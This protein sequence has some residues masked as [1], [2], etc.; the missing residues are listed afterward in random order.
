MKKFNLVKSSERINL[1]LGPYAMKSFVD[2]YRLPCFL[3]PYTFP[4]FILD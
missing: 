3:I 2:C 4:Q 1:R